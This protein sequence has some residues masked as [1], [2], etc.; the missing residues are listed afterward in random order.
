MKSFK[1]YVEACWTGYTAK[2]MKKKGNRMVPNCVPEEVE[3]KESHKIGDSVT[4]NSKFFGKQKGKVVKVDDQSVHVQ[5]NGK[6]YSEK[7]PHDSVI[8]EDG[9]GAG[10][11]GGGPANVV[12]SGAIAGTGGK[13]GE[14]GVSKKRNPVMTPTFKRNPP[15]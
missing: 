7:Y 5:R 14:P 10:A 3:L 1:Q 2:G 15:Q 6:K 12:G 4:V 8:K 11:V 9:M 13:G